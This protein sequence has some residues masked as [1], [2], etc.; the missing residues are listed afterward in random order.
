LPDIPDGMA[1][2]RQKVERRSRVVP[3]PRH[4]AK[5]SEPKDAAPERAPIATAP[6]AADRTS[7]FSAG[8]GVPADSNSAGGQKPKALPPKK[9]G[10]KLTGIEW[11]REPVPP[12]P[13]EPMSNLAIRVRKSLDDRLADVVHDLRRQGIRSSKAEVVE[14]LISALPEHSDLAFSNRL[15]QFRAQAPRP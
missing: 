3:P 1:V 6:P 14:L 2:L 12:D 7:R 11:L 9:T 4:P 5:G 13:N 15:K 8:T 10:V